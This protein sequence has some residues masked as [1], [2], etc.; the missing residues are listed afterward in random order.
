MRAYMQVSAGTSRKPGRRQPLAAP[1]MWP[2]S[3]PLGN[4]VSGHGP[5][6]FSAHM[7]VCTRLPFYSGMSVLYI[8]LCTYCPHFGLTGRSQKALSRSF[9]QA[10]NSRPRTAPDLGT[11]W[12]KVLNVHPGSHHSLSAVLTARTAVEEAKA[13]SRGGGTVIIPNSS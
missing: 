13:P 6:M 9:M 10:M 3:L 4:S 2:W 12:S 1:P 8:L 7:D 5:E 11:A